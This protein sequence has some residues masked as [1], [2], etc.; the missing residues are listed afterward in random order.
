MDYYARN[1]GLTWPAR[2]AALAVAAAAMCA[3]GATTAA[4]VPGQRVAELVSNADSNGSDVQTL[5]RTDGEGRAIAWVSLGAY[6]G[7]RGANGAVTYVGRRGGAG[8]GVTPYWPRAGDVRPGAV[9]LMGGFVFPRDLSAMFGVTRGAFDAS[10]ADYIFGS[11]AAVD[12]YRFDSAGG[13]VWLSHGQGMPA[14]GTD[15]VSLVGVSEDGTTVFFTT[16]EPLTPDAPNDFTSQLYRWR[17]GTVEAV[18]RDTGG[19]FFA[20]GSG[21]GNATS[22]AVDSG[23]G[24]AGQVADSLAVSSDGSRFVY[25][26]GVWPFVSGYS[27][28]YLH[29]DG[30]PLRQ[31]TLSQRDET[32]GEPA[33]TGAVMVASTP[34]LRKIYLQSPDQLTNDAPADGGDYVY[35]TESGILSF[36]HPDDSVAI[37]PNPDGTKSG[38][39]RVSD[40]GAY[41][42]FLSTREIGG[43]GVAGE[44][45]LYVKHGDE[46]TLIGTLDPT[47]E[48]DLLGVLPLSGQ[49]SY[50]EYTQSGI[51]ADGTRLA[52]LSVASLRGYDTGGHRSVYRYDA[53]DD[54]LSCVSCRAD[55]SQ[56]QGDAR[57]M[58]TYDVQ[59]RTPRV[60]SDDGETIAF[61]T[62]DGLVHGDTNRGED[63]YEHRDG[64]LS[65]VSGGTSRYASTFGGLSRDGVDLYLLTRDSL[66]PEDTDNGFTDVYD[67]RIGGRVAQRQ[68]DPPGCEG[69]ECQ[70]TATPRT[71]PTRPGSADYS[72]P[73]GVEEREPAARARTFSVKGL[74]ARQRRALAR[75]GRVTV[76]VR[77]S[78]AGRV[79]V[80]LRTR[81]KR[82][83]ATTVASGRR[84]AARAATVKV[85]LRLSRR[86]RSALDGGRRLTVSMSVRFSKA[87]R[88]KTTRF[89]VQRTARSERKEVRR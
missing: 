47:I 71:S 16:P 77:T 52:F 61:S 18:G 17:A 89:A 12:A 87:P 11:L 83:A 69:D 88:A 46:T 33:P 28:V 34:E 85:P 39:V 58:P 36:S 29:E 57:F 13:A 76:T 7:T 50:P 65:I 64:A 26:D 8:W 25:R 19:A 37:G 55:G 2:T 3:I 49:P 67:V 56:S 45:N 53:R 20:T 43:E 27:Q 21:L 40:D 84:T 14:T 62:T 79:T 24:H 38:I 75:T 32:L 41:V 35:D 72:G 54:S 30:Q 15:D 9:S 81:L 86:A 60:I 73:G 10:D 80:T 22:M 48:D 6:G 59:V 42:Y 1:A 23:G 78:A 31:L 68:G 70:G 5:L 44:R 51:S 82:G 63:V 4:A 66:S 74:S